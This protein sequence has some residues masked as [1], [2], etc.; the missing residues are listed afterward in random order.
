MSETATTFGLDTA[1][2]VF[3]SGASEE[4]GEH[5]AQLG[6]TRALVVCD[7]FVS[8][9]GLVERLQASLEAAGV[10]SSV[11]DRIAG[12]PSEASVAEAGEAAREGYDGFVGIGGGSAL[13]TAKLCA[14]FATHGGE[15]LD[16]V[17]APIGRGTPVPGPVLPAR[18]AAHDLGDRARRSRRSP[19][20]T[21]LASGRRPA[22]RTGTSARRSRSSIRR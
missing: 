6:I 19:S 5:V 7:P 15:L 10:E 1:R 21:S 2:I 11:Y 3:G 20:S 8:G 16:Y 9:S 22:S 17:N 13:D 18:R 14:L 4:T 12:E